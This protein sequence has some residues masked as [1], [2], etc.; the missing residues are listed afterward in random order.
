MKS[1]KAPSQTAKPCC[2]KCAFQ[3]SASAASK[4]SYAAHH[5]MK[6]CPLSMTGVTRIVAT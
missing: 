1:R 3:W 5:S 4:Q 6:A 2:S